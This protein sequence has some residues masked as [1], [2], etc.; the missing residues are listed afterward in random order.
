MYSV[1]GPFRALSSEMK[2]LK[3]LHPRLSAVKKQLG[4]TR[5]RAGLTVESR[6]SASWPGSAEFSFCMYDLSR[7][8]RTDT[9]RTTPSRSGHA[10]DQ[11]SN[12]DHAR[13]PLLETDGPRTRGQVRRC[14]HVTDQRDLHQA[15][16]GFLALHARQPPPTSVAQSLWRQP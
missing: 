8:L 9:Q 4:T 10:Q 7:G 3:V 16:R 11:H 13:P 12:H 5:T 14:V 6:D 2:V 15:T 1:V